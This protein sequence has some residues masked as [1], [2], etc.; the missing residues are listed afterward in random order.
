MDVNLKANTV[1]IGDAIKVLKTEL[2]PI[3][4]TGGI[5]GGGGKSTIA[6]N[7]AVNQALKNRKVLLIDIDDDVKSA[8]RF[9]SA[10]AKTLGG[11]IGYT[12]MRSSPDVLREQV[13]TSKKDYDDVILDSGGR[14]TAG[15]RVALFLTDICLCPFYPRGF[16]VWTLKDFISLV[17]EVQSI[18]ETKLKIIAFL[19]RADSSGNDNSS[20]LE[21]LK[22]QGKFIVSEKMIVD[23][24]A[25]ANA[26]AQGLSVFEYKPK[27]NKAI[28]EMTALF[29]YIT[30]DF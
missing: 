28:D 6:T 8:T 20:A 14:D 7:F 2:M 25:I 30:K 16:D 21:A 9:S 1:P 12:A 29:N 23:R 5:K 11:S 27:D 10:R 26:G 24:K 22:S 3:Y 15:Q 17:M 19:N 13:M 4:T 18:R